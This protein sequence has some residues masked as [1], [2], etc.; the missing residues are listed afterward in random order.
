M[1]PTQRFIVKSETPCTSG[2]YLA[3]A[4]T[5]SQRLDSQTTQN[6]FL[7]LNSMQ[8]QTSP[9]KRSHHHH[10][11]HHHSN[12]NKAQIAAEKSRSHVSQS[13]NTCIGNFIAKRYMKNDKDNTSLDAYDLASP[14][15]ESNMCVPVKRRSKHHHKHKHR[16]SSKS[17]EKPPRPKSQSH[18]T[19][20]KYQQTDLCNVRKNFSFIFI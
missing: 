5:S 6:S 20:H 1:D 17:R 19:M 4:S 16:E 12:E 10:H 2:E 8:Q 9:V 7:S 11:H 13:C 15:C 3:S 14:C 18:A